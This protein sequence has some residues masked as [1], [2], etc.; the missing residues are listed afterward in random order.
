MEDS[1]GA[2]F[3]LDQRVPSPTTR[4]MTTME[5]ADNVDAQLKNRVICV[6]NHLSAAL[7]IRVGAQALTYGVGHRS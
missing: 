7:A 1:D 4:W 6:S 2:V 3:D 5:A